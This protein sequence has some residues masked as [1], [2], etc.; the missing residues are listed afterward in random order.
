MDTKIKVAVAIEKDGKLLMLREYDETRNASF[1]N[2]VKG[3]YDKGGETLME[4]A[5]RE[6]REEAGLEVELTGLLHVTT[7]YEKKT[8]VQF[9]FV[10]T[11]VGEVEKKPDADE[12]FEEIRWMDKTDL[13]AIPSEHFMN[14]RTEA[15]VKQWLEGTRYPLSVLQ[16]SED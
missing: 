2:I 10:G 14:K 15:A 7:R 16:E 4:C 12:V 1:W 8:R 5:K 3:T 13:E 6:C 9:N 11:P